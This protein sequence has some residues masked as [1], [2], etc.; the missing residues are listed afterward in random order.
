[1]A[2]RL[3]RLDE[4]AEPNRDPRAGEGLLPAA[5]NPLQR[6]ALQLRRERD[7]LSHMSLMTS[8]LASKQSADVGG[9][10]SPRWFVD[11]PAQARGVGAPRPQKPTALRALLF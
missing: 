1:M 2:L 10:P 9:V 4:R 7:V 8:S 3:L 11:S 6:H 5:K